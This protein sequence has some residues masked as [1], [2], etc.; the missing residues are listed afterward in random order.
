MSEAFPSLKN[1]FLIAL[2][3]LREGIFAH[4]ITY[5]CEHDEDGA[6][7][8]IINRPL[9]MNVD[10][11]LDQLELDEHHHTHHQS[12]YAGGPVQTDRGFVL[13]RRSPED[14]E[15]TL[16]VSNEISLTS[17]VDILEAIARNTGP[18]Q[19]LIALGYA[20]WA[21]GQL[22]AELA[23]SSWLTLPVDDRILFDVPAP[24]R[25]DAALAKLGIS[26]AQL[27]SDSGLA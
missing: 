15:A 2:P 23:E 3:S 22:E 27:G 7:G 25:V 12:V 9:D 20:G 26:F 13:H 19:S 18:T 1:Q 17:S 16:S 21:A 4:S 11:V 24:A 14:W 5:L 8:I 6:M 10:E